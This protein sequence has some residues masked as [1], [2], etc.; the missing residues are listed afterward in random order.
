MNSTNEGVSAYANGTP[1]EVRRDLEVPRRNVLR[2]SAPEPHGPLESA[3]KQELCLHGK[4]RGSSGQ[5]SNKG[6]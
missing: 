3:L 1:E 2:L 6:K 5:Q 4:R